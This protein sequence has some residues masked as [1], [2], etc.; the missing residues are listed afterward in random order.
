MPQKFCPP[1]QYEV[2]VLYPYPKAHLPALHVSLVE[3][4]NWG[5]LRVRSHLVQFGEQA[6]IKES[7]QIGTASLF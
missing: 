5:L 7:S 3:Q 6:E 2:T 1:L 4:Q